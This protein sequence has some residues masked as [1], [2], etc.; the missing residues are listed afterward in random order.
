MRQTAAAIGS[1]SG[2]R[3]PAVVSNHN[4]NSP[5]LC[6]PKELAVGDRKA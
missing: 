4:R 2:G 1:K 5:Q 3:Q 6:T